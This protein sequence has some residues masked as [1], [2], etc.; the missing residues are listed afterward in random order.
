MNHPQRDELLAALQELWRSPYPEDSRCLCD[1]DTQECVCVGRR[2]G[3]AAISAPCRAGPTAPR[4]DVLV[5]LGFTFKETYATHPFTYERI[6]VYSCSRLVETPEEAAD[7]A[8][9]VAC[10]YFQIPPDKWLYVAFDENPDQ[11]PELPPRPP[12]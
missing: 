1:P 2:N 4:A 7:V 3:R 8:L 5:R 6:R 12:G 11:W 9:A 10:D